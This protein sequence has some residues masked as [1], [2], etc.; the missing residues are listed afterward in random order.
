MNKL[1][2]LGLG[3][4]AMAFARRCITWGWQV[5]GT[6]RSQARTAAISDAG[7][8]P[9]IFDGTRPSPELS[10]ALATAT[11]VL[12]SI[13]PDADGDPVLIHHASDLSAASNIGW[14][15]Y[16][17]TVGVYGNHDGAWVDETTAVAPVSRRSIQRVAAEQA[18]QEAS[19][20][21]GIPLQIF[22]LSG[23]YGPGRSP[24]D[25][26]RAGTARRLI[27]PGQVFN[28]IHVDDIAATLAAACAAPDLPG[29]YN[30]TDDLPAPPQDVIAFA[31][32]LIGID[33]PP[34]IPFDTA[35]ISPMARSFY[36]EN[37]RVRNDRIKRELGVKLVYPTYR[38][39]LTAIASQT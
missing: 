35:D 1:L 9:L 24:I 6:T 26:L 22:R 31:A 20:T 30:V 23:I 15:G 28:R 10:R 19:R 4:S 21:H 36:G 2:C 25:R 7:I 37:K 34:E 14:L 29:I 5:S 17:S 32:A 12:I 18:W 13:A 3:Y 33:P 16:L 38:E 8:A 39:G 27:K 11:H